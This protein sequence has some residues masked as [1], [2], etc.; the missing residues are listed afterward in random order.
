MLTNNGLN[1]LIVQQIGGQKLYV[2]L[3]FLILELVF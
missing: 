2:I 3:K 1:S